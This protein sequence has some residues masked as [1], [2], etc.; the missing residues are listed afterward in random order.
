MSEQADPV[1][2]ALEMDVARL[3]EDLRQSEAELERLR[4]GRDLHRRWEETGR[5][6]AIITARATQF[7][8]QEDPDLWKEEAELG[9][10]WA[11]RAQWR[12]QFRETADNVWFVATNDAPL[13]KQVDDFLGWLGSET[14]SQRTALARTRSR[15]ERASLLS[16]RLSRIS[17]ARNESAERITQELTSI[18]RFIDEFSR[19][20]EAA[21]VANM[22]SDELEIMVINFAIE[23]ERLN[24]ARHH[25]EGAKASLAHGRSLARLDECKKSLDQAVAR[26]AQLKT[27][28]ETALQF[29]EKLKSHRDNFVQEQMTAL[30]PAVESLFGRM[31]ANHVF[32][33]IRSGNGS[34][35]L[36]WFAEIDGKPLATAHFSQGQRQD[37]ALAIFLARAC[38]LKGSFFLDEPFVHL[39]DLNRVAMLDILRAI[40]LSQPDVHL[41]LT[42]ASRSLARHIHEKF[43]ML[44]KSLLQIIELQGDPRAEKIN[45]SVM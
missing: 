29:Q 20:F 10:A 18:Q 6:I 24:R 5:T 1:I 41:V 25:L 4:T 33:A 17:G 27:R 35:P 30:L 26:A 39:D 2:R 13:A 12:E 16:R 31:H 8:L 34:D 9:K 7:G 44:D 40:A 43:A 21:T 37:L 22:T 19:N 32:D 42:T 28:R 3:A 38:G 14:R 15:H 45:V 23:R 36:Q 11:E